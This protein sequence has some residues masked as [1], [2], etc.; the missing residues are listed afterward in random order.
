M[1]IL[2][3]VLNNYLNVDGINFYG[4]A[5]WLGYFLFIYWSFPW[6]Y[7]SVYVR[8]SLLHKFKF[9]LSISSCS[10]T[11]VYKIYVFF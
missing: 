1:D 2:L 6:L 7:F 8:I 4:V 10:Y 5:Y 3:C 9:F 11:K